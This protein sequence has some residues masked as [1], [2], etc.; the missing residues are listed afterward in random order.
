MPE[1]PEVQRVVD[2]LNEAARGR[3]IRAVQVRWPRYVEGVAADGLPALLAGQTIGTARRRG[4]YILLPLEHHGLVLHLR[5]TGQI[6]KRPAGDEPA[7]THVV[8]ELD[9]EERIFFADARK[10]GRMVVVPIGELDAAEAALPLGVEPIGESFTPEYLR[11]VCAG[12]AR[13]IKNILMD[14]RLIAGIGNIYACEALWLAGIDPFRSGDRIGK[15]EFPAIV[16]AVREILETALAH[17]GA[18]ISDYRAV[19]GESGTM[20]N[21]FIVYGREKGT[22]P[23]CNE[24]IRRLPDAGRSSFWCPGCQK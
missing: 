4:K 19:N 1:L 11:T 13:S 6:I 8:F 12:R 7:H 17:G 22:C 16:R 5:M 18:S 21:H 23:R 24:T 20:Q 15:K 3:T 9:D 2:G 10:F 14:Q